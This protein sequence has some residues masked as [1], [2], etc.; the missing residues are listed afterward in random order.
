MDTSVNFRFSFISLLSES[1]SFDGLRFSFC[2]S[3][4]YLLPIGIGVLRLVYLWHVPIFFCICQQFRSTFLAS[5]SIISVFLFIMIHDDL[6]LFCD[7]V[8]F[9]SSSEEC[10]L[11]CS[12]T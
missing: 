11:G 3:K 7:F 5:F 6:F 10:K 12:L 2:H 4:C 8:T 9:F 1:V